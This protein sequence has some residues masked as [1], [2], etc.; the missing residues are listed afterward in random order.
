MI[1]DDIRHMSED[2]LHDI[3]YFLNEDNAFGED[4]SGTKDFY[5]F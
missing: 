4:F 3:D 5:I 1:T 2:D